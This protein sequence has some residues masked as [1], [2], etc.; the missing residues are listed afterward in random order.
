M[1]HSTTGWTELKLIYIYIYTHTYIYI[2]VCVYIYTHTHTH[3]H[4]VIHNPSGNSELGCTTTKTD[5]AERITS[6]GRE[7]LQV[8]SCTRRRGV[9][10]GFTARGQSWRNMAW[11]GNRKALCLEI[12]QNWVN[13]DGATEVSDHVPHRTT[14]G[15][16][17]SW[18]V[19]EIPVEW[20]PVSCET[21]I[22]ATAGGTNELPC[23]LKY[24]SR[25]FMKRLK[26]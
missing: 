14:Y 23:I 4:R 22:T 20:L 12:C 17:N 19:H 18:V 26:F 24:V 5:T 2:Y 11:T 1:C 16:N 9:L 13:C 25:M 3:T 6:I 21:K 10:A 8:F 15:Q 7:S